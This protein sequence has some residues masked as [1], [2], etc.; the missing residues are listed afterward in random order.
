MK[1]F[2]VYEEGVCFAAYRARNAASAIRKAARGCPR[3]RE[4]YYLSPDAEPFTINWHASEVGGSGY[5]MARV[6]VPSRGTQG[7]VVVSEL[8]R[9]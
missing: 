5:A 8:K 3:T 7:V 6:L 1:V 9:K 2:Q 4:D